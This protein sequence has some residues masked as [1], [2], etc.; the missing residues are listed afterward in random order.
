MLNLVTVC[1]EPAVDV[2]GLEVRGVTPLVLEV[3]LPAAGVHRADVVWQQGKLLDIVYASE[4]PGLRPTSVHHLG[5]VSVLLRVLE[6]HEVH[7]A[8][9]A[10]VPRVEPV[11]VLEL[12]PGFP[13]RQEVVVLAV[14]LVV[15]PVHA[16]LHL[17]EGVLHCTELPWALSPPTLGLLSS[18]LPS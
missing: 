14:L 11:P 17:G 12:V 5:E 13:P 9:P 7:A 18:G 4:Y 10:E 15:L 16:H 8:L 2:D 6:G 3:A 1:P